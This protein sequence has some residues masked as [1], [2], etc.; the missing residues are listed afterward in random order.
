MTKLLRLIIVIAAIA[1]LA[2][3]VQAQ[4]ADA[5]FLEALWPTHRQLGGNMTGL[6]GDSGIVP[7]PHHYQFEFEAFE[8]LG[9]ARNFTRE[10]IQH[11]ALPLAVGIKE[12]TSSGLEWNPFEGTH[13]NFSTTATSTTDFRE[14]LISSTE[15]STMGFRQ[16]F[17]GA[18]SPTTFGFTR[19]VT[20]KREGPQ[21]EEKMTQW[22]YTLESEP[23]DDWGLSMK[24]CDTEADRPGGYWNRDFSGSLAMPLSGGTA[25]FSL[26][27]TR[28]ISDGNE[29][30]TQT[31]DLVAPFC[32][33]GGEAIAEHHTSY[34]PS[35]KEKHTRLTRF[36]SPLKLL[37]EAGSFEHKIEEKLKAST[38]TEKKT[39]VLS[40][41]FTISGRTI[42]HQ[43][44]LVTQDVDG[45]ASET[46]RT[47]LSVP[48]SGGNAVLHRQVKTKPNG[49]D[50]EWKQRQLVLKTPSFHIGSIAKFNVSRSTTETV[51]EDALRVTDLALDVHPFDPL[52]VA[53]KWNL[54]DN[55]PETALKSRGV[56]TSWE[57]TDDLAL[58]Y[59]FTEQEVIDKT[60]TIL[61]HLELEKTPK[62]ASGFALSAGYVS[63]GADG[64]PAEPAALVKVGVGKEGV[65][66]LDAKYSEFDDR[67][68]LDRYDEHPFIEVI[69]RHSS[70]QN[71][72]VQ[73]RYQ[74][75]QG[76]DD[77]ERGIRFAFGA[78]G[79]NMQLGYGQNALGPDGKNIRRADVYDAVLDRKIFGGDVNFKLG[80][81]YCDYIEEELIEQH[82][83]IRVD[84]GDED[85][86]GKVSLS[87]F[88]GEFV[89]NP[90]RSEILPRSV[91]KL[92]YSRTWGDLGRLSLTL[93]RETAP[94]DMP[95]EEGNIAGQ[96]RFQMD[97]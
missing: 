68:K 85:G 49:D 46:F 13:L 41:P 2:A 27:S 86:G 56:N 64:E 82:Y 52:D 92:G 93:N 6:A 90:K 65:I 78:L 67:K 66:R 53:A 36:F 47:E 75:Q 80:V 14:M 54:T 96:L 7:D 70:D 63:Y 37:G 16:D 4:A 38:L 9:L 12:T 95:A 45:V 79:G 10:A 31:V 48:I 5:M 17:G 34:D 62:T 87:Y 33:S 24:L 71:R 11:D 43:H 81:R 69:L 97:F 39:T 21:P 20:S 60:P 50:G 3:T 61:R 25:T 1:G 57:F 51:G 94:D 18:S 28:T 84:G 59:A 42:G 29:G 58:R 30:K 72:S 15:V 73:L 44:S 22:Q 76:R 23:A 26:T 40:L 8:N 83:D 55:G 77:P 88:S 35:A 19:E 91:F 32:I 89:P 74:D